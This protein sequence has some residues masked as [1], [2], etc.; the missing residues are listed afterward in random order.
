MILIVTERSK[1]PRS[2]LSSYNFSIGNR[3][4][5]KGRGIVEYIVGSIN[6]NVIYNIFAEMYRKI[7]LGKWKGKTRINDA[8]RFLDCST[9]GDLKSILGEIR[10]SLRR[11][12]KV[13]ITV[14][15]R[16][17]TS[18]TY[19]CVLIELYKYGGNRFYKVIMPIV[20][21][22]D[23]V[24]VIDLREVCGKYLWARY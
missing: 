11:N 8:R 14:S 1:Y 10:S 20:V 19:Y 18:E 6:E 24:D 2:L 23:H 13:Y 16:S 9:L 15:P 7:N 5:Y 3:G 17:M 12:G 21:V 4:K 22:E